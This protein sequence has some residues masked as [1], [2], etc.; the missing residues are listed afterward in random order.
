MIGISAYLYYVKIRI[1]VSLAYRFE[2]FFSMLSNS[3]IMLSTVYF[4]RS[5]YRGIEMIAGVTLEQMITYSIISALLGTVFSFNVENIVN[6]R[7]REGDIAIDFLKPLNIFG[8]YFAQDVGTV[9]SSLIQKFLPMLMFALLFIKV[10]VPHS[11]AHFVL[12]L[13]SCLF[14]YLIL[15]LLSAITGLSAFWIIEMGPMGFVKN[16]IVRVLSG[17]IIPIWF[18]PSSIQKLLV[19]LPFT[20]TYQLPVGIYI[21]KIKFQEAT[22]SMLIQIIWVLI[23]FILFCTMQKKAGK[24]L[25]VQ[26][27]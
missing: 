10:P 19:F 22:W 11:F 26:G 8:L 14:S 13:I 20:Y 12:F 21:G 5:A 7:I 27:G 16:A 2:V 25:L 1:L 3:I 18:F 15:W 9:I 23:L 17:S 4:W 6:E 24:N